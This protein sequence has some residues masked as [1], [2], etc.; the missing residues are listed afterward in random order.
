MDCTD[1]EDKQGKMAA[2]LALEEF[3][4]KANETNV[5]ITKQYKDLADQIR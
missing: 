4:L 5:L 2:N 3:K 1:T